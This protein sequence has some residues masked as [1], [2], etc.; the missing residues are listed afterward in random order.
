MT[1]HEKA[2]ALRPPLSAHMCTRD[3]RA[4][5]CCAHVHT[6]VL[7]MHTQCTRVHACQGQNTC[8]AVSLNNSAAA[9]G[10]GRGGDLDVGLGSENPVGRGAEAAAHPARLPPP[11]GA[12]VTRFSA[13]RP[14]PGS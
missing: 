11:P 6:H 12:A 13:R 2:E 9:L 1:C 5:T 3:A 14:A 4:R 10:V 8:L 7:R